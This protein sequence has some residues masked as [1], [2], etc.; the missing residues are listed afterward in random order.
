MLKLFVVRALFKDVYLWSVCLG[1]Q[2]SK[3]LGNTKLG[4]EKMRDMWRGC[5]VLLCSES[6][7]PR[8]GVYVAAST[9]SEVGVE[10]D[11]RGEN[12]EELSTLL[13]FLLLFFCF[14]F[15]RFRSLSWKRGGSERVSDGVC[16]GSEAEVQGLKV[17]APV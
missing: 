15:F 17:E 6:K 7:C 10:A 11:E 5:V 1:P 14:S 4:R 8:G 9:S 12:P 3:L 2:N 16:C 13:L